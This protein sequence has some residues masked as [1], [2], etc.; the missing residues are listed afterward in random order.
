VL[1]VNFLILKLPVDR[2]R[3]WQEEY[4]LLSDVSLSFILQC[5]DGY[6]ARHHRICEF[7]HEFS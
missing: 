4:D 3:D 7:G 5:Y 1:L 6:N 2:Y